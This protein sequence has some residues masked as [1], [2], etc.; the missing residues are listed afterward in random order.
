MLAEICSEPK[1]PVPPARIACDV[2]LVK[3][4]HAFRMLL[5]TTSWRKPAK[6]CE[7]PPKVLVAPR[8]YPTGCDAGSTEYSWSSFIALSTPA[9]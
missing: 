2:F 9:N 4:T 5:S 6:S 8:E 3:S 1:A 7:P